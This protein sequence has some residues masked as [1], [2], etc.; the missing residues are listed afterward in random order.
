MIISS[1]ARDGQPTIEIRWV[2]FGAN[3]QL[4]YRSVVPNVDAS[5]SLC[6]PGQWSN[7]KIVQTIEANDAA[8][9]DVRASGGIAEAP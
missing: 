2:K 6:P 7:W 9:D 5:G 3:R 8:Y 4:E 1:P